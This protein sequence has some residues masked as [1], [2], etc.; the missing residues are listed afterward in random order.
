MA[1]FDTG[2]Q[3]R[4]FHLGVV[5]AMRVSGNVYRISPYRIRVE[6]AAELRQETYTYGFERIDTE[7]SFLLGRAVHKPRITRPVARGTVWGRGFAGEFDVGTNAG[8]F[9]ADFHG[10][11]VSQGNKP[12]SG[13][14]WL[15]FDCGYPIGAT[16]PTGLS[17]SD[18]RTTDKTVT[19]N[20]KIDS[21][22]NGANDSLYRELQVGTENNTNN[23]LF[24]FSNGW[25]KNG[26]ITV[27][28]NSS[29]RG[30][31]TI[32]PNTKYYLGLYASN[33]VLNTGSVF[34]GVTAVTLATS[35]IKA[36]QIKP[37]AVTFDVKATEGY[38]VPATAIEYR[39]RGKEDWKTSTEVSGGTGQITVTG[40]LSYTN[41]DFR[42]K[43]TTSDGTW[44]SAQVSLRTKPN[45]KLIY[46]NGDSRYVSMKLIYQ[47]GTK[48][49]AIK[50]KKIV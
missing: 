4:T 46:S 34:P 26:D 10:C 13:E 15:G 9:H 48:K 33:G 49:I 18:V 6:G 40:L 29:K 24:W 32:K 44:R 38:R 50:A 27:D 14:Q 12:L 3:P 5:Y 17:V 7:V 36:V 41:Y 23:Q 31:I 20:V 28:N 39:Q 25:A 35:T 42:A 47:D 2:W 21:W 30:T 22:G 45:M 19:A 43:T 8:N 11:S 16:P 1:R 37:T